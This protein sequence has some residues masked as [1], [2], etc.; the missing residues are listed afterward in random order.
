PRRELPAPPPACRGDGG[1]VVGRFPLAVIP[2][3]HPPESSWTACRVAASRAPGPSV[4]LAGDSPRLTRDQRPA[5]VA[6]A[7]GRAPEES[8]RR[9][10]GRSPRNRTRVAR[11]LGAGSRVS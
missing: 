3:A 5:A 9:G 7:T 1:P 11:G 8:A 10:H 6:A 4:R 2:A